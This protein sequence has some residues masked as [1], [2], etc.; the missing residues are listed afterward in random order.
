MRLSNS[1]GKIYAKIYAAMYASLYFLDKDKRQAVS[2]VHL[3]PPK[4][5]FAVEISFVK[6]CFGVVSV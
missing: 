1:F 5:L 6:R 3:I 4:V 2:N